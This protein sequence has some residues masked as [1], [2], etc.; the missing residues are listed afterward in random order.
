M[1]NIAI[2]ISE[3]TQHLANISIQ[4]G[5]N[6]RKRGVKCVRNKEYPGDTLSVKKRQK[7]TNILTSG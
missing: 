2:D 7:V 4:T 6:S 1:R 3:T 5:I